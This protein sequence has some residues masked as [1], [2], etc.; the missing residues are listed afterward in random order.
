M[1]QQGCGRFFIDAEF[2][3]KSTPDFLR[4]YAYVTHFEAEYIGDLA[5]HFKWSLC[6]APY[7]ELSVFAPVRGYVVWFD[8]SLVYCSGCKFPLYDYVGFF[9]SLF[10][11]SLF[12]LEVVCDVAGLICFFAEGFH[13]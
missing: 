11:V 12:V 8:V 10:Y 5:A 2:S 1:R 3:A 6:A 9:K 13:F 7:C 4:D